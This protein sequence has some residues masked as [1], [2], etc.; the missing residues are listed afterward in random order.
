M[1]ICGQ[2]DM[3]VPWNVMFLDFLMFY[4]TLACPLA[5]VYIVGLLLEGDVHLLGSEL[6]LEIRW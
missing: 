6:L 3:N 1:H 4:Q 5:C 2:T